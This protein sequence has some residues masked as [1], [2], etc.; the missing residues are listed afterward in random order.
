MER[1]QS[2]RRVHATSKRTMSSSFAIATSETRAWQSGIVNARSRRR[3]AT[4]PRCS[5]RNEY[6]ES[7]YSERGSCLYVITMYFMIRNCEQQDV[8]RRYL[9]LSGDCTIDCQDVKC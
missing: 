9:G 4:S 1:P 8:N 6:R 2:W 7:S 3:P 5:A